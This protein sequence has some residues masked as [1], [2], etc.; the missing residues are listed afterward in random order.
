MVD[1]F[2]DIAT[3]GTGQA[4]EYKDG[5]AYRRNGTGPD[6]AVFDIA[7][8][9]FSGPDAWDGETRNSTAAAPLPIGRYTTASVPEASVLSLMGIA[10][11]WLPGLSA[12]L[13][14]RSGVQP[15]PRS[16][17]TTSSSRTSTAVTQ[18]C[19]MVSCNASSSP[20]SSPSE[21]SR[22]SRSSCMA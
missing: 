5:W 14:G 12:S 11:L 20:A 3:D 15:S 4:W 2:G 10:L 18:A 6:G 13:R 22:R 16:R 17:A 7:N 21:V 19:S 9:T 1:A 8:W